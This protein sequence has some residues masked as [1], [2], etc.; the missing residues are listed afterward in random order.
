MLVR[1][2][3]ATKHLHEHSKKTPPGLAVAAFSLCHIVSV[4]ELTALTWQ[5]PRVARDLLYD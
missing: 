4:R 2:T 1:R 3:P 5:A